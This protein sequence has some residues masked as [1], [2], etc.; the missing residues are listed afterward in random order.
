MQYKFNPDDEQSICFMKVED[1][2][3][4]YVSPLESINQFCFYS[5]LLNSM[6]NWS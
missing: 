4:Y 5:I 2:L 6:P 3:D 1:Y